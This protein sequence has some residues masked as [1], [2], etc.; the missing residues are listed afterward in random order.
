MSL[1][2][3]QTNLTTFT[4]EKSEPNAPNSCVPIKVHLQAAKEE[5]ENSKLSGPERQNLRENFF[6]RVLKDCGKKNDYTETLKTLGRM[7]GQDFL[8]PPK[9]IKKN[10]IT[11]FN[12]ELSLNGENVDNMFKLFKLNRNDEDGMGELLGLKPGNFKDF[13]ACCMFIALKNSINGKPI[14]KSI[15]KM[16]GNIGFLKFEIAEM[17]N[18][19]KS[20]SLRNNERNKNKHDYDND[21]TKGAQKILSSD[22]KDFKSLLN[23]FFPNGNRNMDKLHRLMHVVI[24][25]ENIDSDKKVSLVN[26]LSTIRFEDGKIVYSKF[27]KTVRNMINKNQILS[28]SE[29]EELFK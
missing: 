16:L 15:Y 7:T 14:D 28:N 22:E 10:E 6:N 17:G 12:P 25:N 26:L 1:T 2:H 21:F 19:F 29:K 20:K 8:N 24:S 3:T 4:L 11:E 5:K 13:Y 9:D 18:I 23:D 27:D